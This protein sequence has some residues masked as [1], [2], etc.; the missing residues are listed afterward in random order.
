[1]TTIA[2]ATMFKQSQ[3][4][5][6]RRIGQVDR[7]FDQIVSQSQLNT[8]FKLSFHVAVG[9]STDGTADAVKN[10]L[11]GWSASLGQVHYQVFADVAAGV[12]VASLESSVRFASLSAAA[13]QPFRSAR[14]SGA[15]YV[16]WLESDL[17][18]GD[19]LIASLLE[20]FGPKNEFAA[21]GAVGPLPF[22]MSN[23]QKLFYDTWSMRGYGGQ[24]W[25]NGDYHRFKEG[26]FRYRRLASV[27]CCALIDA[28]VLRAGNIDFGEGCFPALCE[29]VRAAGK[30]VVCDLETEIEHPSSMLV[31]SRLV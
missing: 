7:F 17:I 5:H 12:P 29:S 13:N 19:D 21:I 11:S 1:M 27:G 16:I 14:D 20:A 26:S 24:R 23:G 18:F 22:F 3:E 28:G 31:A 25:S 8:G 10:R 4:W 6:G 2:V 9:E 15:D 30:E